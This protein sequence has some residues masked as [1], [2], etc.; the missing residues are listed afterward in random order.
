MTTVDVP[1]DAI[2]ER[3]QALKPSVNW[4]R[5]LVALLLFVPFMA[6]RAV[7]LAVTGVLYAFAAAQEGYALSRSP[8][9]A[10]RGA[11]SA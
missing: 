10:Q 9:G 8:N 5:V 1:V 4:R 11:E 7:G 2:T 6:G 3:A